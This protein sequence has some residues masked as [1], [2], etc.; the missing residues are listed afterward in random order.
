M[1]TLIKAIFK[2]HLLMNLRNILVA[3][4]ELMHDCKVHDWWRI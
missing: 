1:Y 3:M 4:D 2:T